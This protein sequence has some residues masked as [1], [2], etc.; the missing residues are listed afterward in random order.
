MQKI[1]HDPL[2]LLPQHIKEFNHTFIIGLRTGPELWS[3]NTSRNNWFKKK[4]IL[5][6]IYKKSSC[7]FLKGNSNS[8]ELETQSDWWPATWAPI[9]GRNL[10]DKQKHKYKYICDQQPEA[11]SLREIWAT[12][13]SFLRLKVWPQD[14]A[15]RSPESINKVHHQKNIR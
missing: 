5:H 12:K 11:R 6:L 13:R 1:S 3:A 7:H 8:R 10:R 9:T 14:I 4:N 2:P 15:P